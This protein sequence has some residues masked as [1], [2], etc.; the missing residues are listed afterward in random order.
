MEKR[1]L[2]YGLCQV[3]SIGSAFFLILCSFTIVNGARWHSTC[4][5]RL[6]AT[7]TTNLM[8]MAI[9]IDT[10]RIQESLKNQSETLYLALCYA[11][12]SFNT[13]KT[14]C[15]ER[16]MQQIYSLLIIIPETVTEKNFY[17]KVFPSTNDLKMAIEGPDSPL[18]I[19][20]T[21]YREHEKEIIVRFWYTHS[22]IGGYLCSILRVEKKDLKRRL[23]NYFD[24]VNLAPTLLKRERKIIILAVRSRKKRYAPNDPVVFTCDWEVDLAEKENL[25]IQVSSFLY[26]MKY[27]ARP[28]YG[29]V[30]DFLSI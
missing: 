26:F 30:I 1:I 17:K 21:E 20:E 28:C 13:T 29:Q 9:A 24:G 11:D 4:Q 23:T 18:D 15:G 14:Y 7:K 25:E 3:G 6:S 27:R 2:F 22:Q 8:E 16:D 5:I 19:V 10:K 12:N